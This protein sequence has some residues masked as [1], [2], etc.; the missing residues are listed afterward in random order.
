MGKLFI[1]III[2]NF[3][4]KKSILSAMHVHGI[5]VLKRNIFVFSRKH[6]FQK[7]QPHSAWW[8]GKGK[9]GGCD[10]SLSSGW[11][12]W[13][14]D[15]TELNKGVKQAMEWGLGNRH[16]RDT[17]WENRGDRD[18]K[19][20]P[21]CAM[22]PSTHSTAS[23]RSLGVPLNR[24]PCLSLLASAEVVMLQCDGRVHSL[25]HG[26]AHSTLGHNTLL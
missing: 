14:E 9:F 25:Q 23:F 13:T 19:Q 11:Q 21:N 22:E 12:G 6:C 24:V 3:T 15:D 18:R 20:N 26:A 8:I 5:L 4:G 16:N 10:G 2:N 17:D 1:A 7:M